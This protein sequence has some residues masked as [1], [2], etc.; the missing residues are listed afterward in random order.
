MSDLMAKT[1][2]EKFYSL[3]AANPA[4]FSNLLNH[5]SSV[6]LAQTLLKI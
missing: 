3:P 2:V 6:L 5:L 4:L 1:V